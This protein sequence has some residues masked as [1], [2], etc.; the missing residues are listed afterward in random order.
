MYLEEITLTSRI[1]DYKV[2]F[3][4]TSDFLEKYMID[5]NTVFIV[6]EKVWET[7]SEGLLKNLPKSEIILI[8][9]HEEMKTLE[10]VQNLYDKIMER[11]PKRNMTMISIGGGITQDI[12]GFTASTLYR[13]IKWVFVP[14]TLLAQ[15]DS[16]VGSKT[17]INYKKYKNLI[18]T[19]FP[20]QEI[21][22]NTAFVST[23]NDVDYFS[24]LGEVVKLHLLGGERS[25]SKLIQL[26]PSLIEKKDDALLAAIQDS[27][28]IKQSYIESDEFD[29]GRRNM[30]NF[31]HC[32][33][34]A[35][36]SATQ[37]AI[38]HGQ[39]VVLGMILA[40]IV[41][42]KRGLLSETKYHYFNQV[43]FPI[44]KVNLEDV[45]F[46]I[47][48]IVDAMRQDK[49][50]TGKEL[51]LVMLIDNYEAIKVNDL[52]TEEATNVL[53]EFYEGNI[54]RRPFS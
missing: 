41:A 51:A 53:Q 52:T 37:F 38:P 21:Y 10:S 42:V 13:G 2:I 33:G 35:I 19:F 39:A 50:R 17:S 30:L 49:K 6:D 8:Q 48:E 32:F 5:P 14:T 11:A 28:L 43:L 7:H 46:K 15:A 31:G 29:T 40:N 12:T 9:T 36:E 20:P 26:L 25:V 3:S 47:N 54:M 18:G 16:C 24:G 4:R 27:L 44:I 22:I 23:L 34:H 1:A 45:S